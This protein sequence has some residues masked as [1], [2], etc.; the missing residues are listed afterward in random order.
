MGD[1][2]T[3]ALIC[4]ATYR[5]TKWVIH[6]RMLRTPREAVQAYFEGRY[7][8]RLPEVERAHVLSSDEWQSM[9]AYFLSCP[10]CVSIWVSGAVTLCSAVFISVPAPLLVWLAASAITGYM[11]AREGGNSE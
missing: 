11:S 7:I 5:I 2:L 6:D 4:L 3:V 10:W 9:P 8:N 1:I